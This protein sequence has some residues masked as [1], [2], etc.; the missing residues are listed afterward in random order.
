MFK[1]LLGAL[2]G[3][4]LALVVA[5]YANI[6]TPAATAKKETAFERVQR[7]G[8]LRCGYFSW[9]PYVMRD[10]NTNELTGIN[11]DYVNAIAAEMGWK[12]VWAA[13]V[14]AGDVVAGL[15]SDKYDMMCASLWTD[16]PRAAALTL[17][18]PTFYT[19]VFAFVRT[20]DTR[21]DG[22]LNKLNDPAVTLAVM[23]GDIT[24]TL[25]KNNYPRAKTQ[26]LPQN[27]DGA[28]VMMLVSTGKADAAIV[29]Q[30]EVDHFN[31]TNTIKLQRVAGVGAAY[32]FP[33]VLAVKSGEHQFKAAVDAIL[34]RLND[35]GLGQKLLAKYKLDNC[36]PA[37][38]GF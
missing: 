12:V 3:A 37:R 31:A 13:E 34:L 21:F 11:V 38:P 24:S 6:G 7:T 5:G 8:E 30:A 4:V 35:N 16:G 26:A 29:G 17:T 10:P 9:P 15:D 25:A 28:E 14:G 32:I 1:A 33:E 22:D 2:I 36:F 19:A 23:D 20:G 18:Q 27:A